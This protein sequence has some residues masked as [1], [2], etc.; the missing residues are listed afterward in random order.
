[1]KN[2][3]MYK[4]INILIC[5]CLLVAGIT[6]DVSAKPKHRKAYNKRIILIDAG[7]GGID[8]GA[9]GEDGILE[10]DINLVIAKELKDILKKDGFYIIMTREDDRGI[11]TQDGRIRKK[12]I[13]DLVNRHSLIE[14]SECNMFISIHLNSFP[15]KQYHGAQVWYAANDKSRSFGEM[16]Q[17]QLRDD[18]DKENKREAKNAKES[19]LILKNPQDIPEVIIEAGFMSN[20]EECKKLENSEYQKQIAKSISEAVIKYFSTSGA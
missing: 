1:M 16:V 9:S 14:N 17:K 3:Y 13:E 20:Y 19:Y 6:Y 11:Y 15:Q 5:T 2:N 8:G 12:K 4:F 7:H 10:K 18:I